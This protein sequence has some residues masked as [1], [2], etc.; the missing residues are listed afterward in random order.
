MDSQALTF[1]EKINNIKTSFFSI[2][3]DFK[4]YYVFYNK[5]PEV[6]E[7]ENFYSN[8]KGQLQQLNSDIFLVTN[9]IQQKIQELNSTMKTTSTKLESEKKLNEELLKLISNIQTTQDGSEIM[10]DDAKEQYNIQ[11]YK[12]WELVIGIIVLTRLT[13]KYFDVK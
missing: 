2:L 9:D 6:N 12:N 13:F 5:N 11:Y 7:Y 3:D 8:S 1:D 10:I 4:K